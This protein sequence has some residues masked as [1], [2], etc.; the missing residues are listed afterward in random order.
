MQRFNL[1]THYASVQPLLALNQQIHEAGRL[2]PALIELVLMRVSQINGCA[3]CLDMHSKDAR[4][5]GETEQRLYVLPAWRETRLFNERERIALHW[6]EEL[7]ELA[8]PEA[9]PDALYQQAREHFEEAELVDLTLL[10][11]AINGWNRINI[12]ARTIGGYYK[13]ARKG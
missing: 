9:L 7:T 4:A 1:Q 6:A 13:P 3:Y 11:V 5:A 8:S 10:V 2:E 12:A